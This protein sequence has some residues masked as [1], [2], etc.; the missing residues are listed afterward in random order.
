MEEP[1]D[2]LDQ[3]LFDAWKNGDDE[4][5]HKC[6]VLLWKKVEKFA[7]KIFSDY[8]LDP[9]SV[10]SEAADAIND[11]ILKLNTQIRIGK[12]TWLDEQSFVAFVLKAVRWACQD[13]LRARRRR[14]QPVSSINQSETQSGEE[15]FGVIFSEERDEQS[16]D[17]IMMEQEAREECICLLNMA[18]RKLESKTELMATLD[19]L[20]KYLT[21]PN[22]DF[23]KT[24][25]LRFV[26]NELAIN[27]NT[28]DQRMKRLRQ[29]LRDLRT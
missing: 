18:R 4:A 17:R 6:W 10:E 27:R 9:S 14:P 12:I 15:V 28:L 20:V 23:A 13:K 11:V 25:M 29:A 21:G 1:R 7:F 24:E 3:Q 5:F 22:A 26:M 19:A 8:G 16:P 2:T